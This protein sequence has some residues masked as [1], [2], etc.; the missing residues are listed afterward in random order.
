MNKIKVILLILFLFASSVKAAKP[1][2]GDKRIIWLDSICDKYKE[3]SSMI[4]HDFPHVIS[5]RC[6]FEFG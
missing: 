3:S 6:K 1:S 2:L 5:W 4:T